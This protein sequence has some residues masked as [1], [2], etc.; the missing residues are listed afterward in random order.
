MTTLNETHDPALS[1]WVESAHDAST[2]FP[3]QNLPFGVFRT[4]GSSESFRGGVAIGNQIV[5]LA[6]VARAGVFTGLAREAAQAASAEKLNGLM[7]LGP[8]SW[9]ALRQSLSQALRVG[10]SQ[11]AA[12]SSCLVPMA[13]AEDRKSTRLNSSH[14]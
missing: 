14:T 10:S 3:I 7:A 12:L 13:A 8:K 4:R 2:D 11:Q 6:A 9:S 1:S 5:D